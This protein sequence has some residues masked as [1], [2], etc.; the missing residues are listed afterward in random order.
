MTWSIVVVDDDKHVLNGMKA[1][2]SKSNLP[3]EVIATASNGIDGLETIAN[4]QPDLI[5]TDI[6]MP[7]LDGIEMIRALRERDFQQKIIILSGYSEFKHAQQAL[8][9]KIEDYLSKPASRA[10]IIQTVEGVLNQLED[11]QRNQRNYQQ[12]KHKVKQ[13]KR[14]FAEELIESAVNGHLNITALQSKQQQMIN[15]WSSYVYLPIKLSFAISDDKAHRHDNQLVSFAISNII[16]DTMYSFNFDYYYIEI[17]Q[18]NSILTIFTTKDKGSQLHLQHKRMIDN[19][20]DHLSQLLSIEINDQVGYC[21]SSWE[22]TIS[23]IRKLLLPSIQT[24]QE[25]TPIEITPIKKELALAIRSTDIQYIQKTL[26]NYF[27]QMIDKSFVSPIA[28]YIGTELWN[29]FNYEL[30]DCGINIS[31]QV[32]HLFNPYQ[33]FSQ[34]HSW[35]ELKHF[36]QNL[37]NTIKNEPIFQQNIRHSKLIED[38][39][40]YVDKNLHRPITLNEIAEELYISRNYLGKIFKETMG[41]TFKEYLTKTRIDKARKMLLSGDYMIYEVAKAVGYDNP[42]YF[43]ALFKKILGYS[44]SQLLN[45]EVK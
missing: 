35:Q 42:A 14:Y 34:F 32:D 16:E 9:L 37:L 36:F 26:D 38:V 33:H 12:F 28:M 18:S 43:S 39:L 15:E 40:K 2:L 21:T 29:I 6:Y 27:N 4:K 3:C 11:E 25:E 23:A 19:L 44:P 1:T 31:D 5:I 7:K 30:Q 20:S 17:D 8:K 24:N 45:K 13:Y 22:E 41:I 10:T